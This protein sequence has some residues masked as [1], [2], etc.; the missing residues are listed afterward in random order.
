LILISGS[1]ADELDKS[2]DAHVERYG[3]VGY[4]ECEI[5]NFGSK[6]AVN[7]EFEVPESVFSVHFE[8]KIVDI[9]SSRKIKI[10]TLR[11]KD[12]VY[13]NFFSINAM[14]QYHERLYSIN[15]DDGVGVI[16]V[17]QPAYGWTGEFVEMIDSGAFWFI[18][19]IPVLLI[20]LYGLL[21]SLHVKNT[22]KL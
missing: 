18:L 7:V 14:S 9:S 11:P 10:G 5:G 16:S 6:N 12:S 15:Y 19:G 13:I 8:G 22:L 21:A 4:S 20:F 17:A 3:D 1:L 2:F